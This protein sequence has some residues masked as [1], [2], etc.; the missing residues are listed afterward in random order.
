MARTVKDAK[1][2]TRTARGRLPVRDKPHWRCLVPG[3]LHLGYRRRRADA[4]GTWTVRRYLGMDE[5]GAGRYGMELLGLADDFQDADGERVLSFA[6]A[7]RLAHDRVQQ[8]V[9]QAAEAASPR[10]MTVADALHD[11][12]EH[13]RGERPRALREVEGR[14]RTH[15]LP[16]FKDTLITSL[17]TDA[18]MRWRDKMA[19]APARLRTR[20]GE[21]QRYKAKPDDARPRRAT[22]NRTVTVLKA[23]LNHAFA[24]G[25]VADDIAWRRLKPFGRVDAARPG[26][27]SAED[28]GR[29]IKAAD[30]DSGFRDLVHAGLLTGCRYGE[31]C[32]LQVKDFAQNRIQIA[33]SKSGKARIVRLEEEGAAF[34]TSLA[35]GRAPDEYLLLRGDGEPWGP[36][37]QSRPMAA[38]CK[39]ARLQ[40]IG[41]HQLRHTWASLAVMNGMPLMLV[42]SN[43][44]HSDTRMVEKHYGHLTED[45]MA[46]EIRSSAPRYGVVR[47]SN[48]TPMRG[49]K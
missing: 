14:A 11:Y 49:A 8:A 32:A 15:I 26:F 31:L 37:H 48:V 42:A 5:G 6:D 28:A 29:L 3:Q 18:L 34:F 43:L 7:Q 30:A 25:R 33:R 24:A 47:D 2:D 44:G 12:V 27:L 16:A 17:T 40:H 20:P 10:Q 38:A 19:A 46:E 13:L 45:Y 35:A 21:E 36:S 23:A 41:F 1:M 4:P 22:V 9:A 39:A